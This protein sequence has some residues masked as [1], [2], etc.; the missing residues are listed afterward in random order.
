MFKCLKYSDLDQLVD[1]LTLQKN[2]YLDS[3]DSDS[4]SDGENK[5]LKSE[6]SA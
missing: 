1:P 6:M 4:N 3:F 5:L 2:L